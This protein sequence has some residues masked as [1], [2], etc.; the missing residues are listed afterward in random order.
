M[1]KIILIDEAVFL[2]EWCEYVQD[3]GWIYC[4]RSAKTVILLFV[5]FLK[6][7]NSLAS[8]SLIFENSSPEGFSWQ[9]TKKSVFS[10]LKMN[11][12]YLQ[13]LALNTHTNCFFSWFKIYYSLR[14]QSLVLYFYRFSAKRTFKI[15]KIN[16]CIFVHV[17][18]HYNLIEPIS[19]GNKMTSMLNNFHQ[20]FAF[21]LQNSTK[22]MI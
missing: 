12:W 1:L 19:S 13:S 9:N 6:I 20:R 18:E 3:F 21:S 10:V 14:V 16:F 5:G 2:W 4:G 11:S 8:F 22:L 7:K 15:P 17:C